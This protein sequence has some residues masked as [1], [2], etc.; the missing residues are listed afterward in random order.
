MALQTMIAPIKSAAKE[1]IR[2][3]TKER[4]KNNNLWNN[5]LEEHKNKTQ[6]VYH[7]WLGSKSPTEKIVYKRDLKKFIYI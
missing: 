7:K 6:V 2:G 1:A 5:T 4:T 3:E